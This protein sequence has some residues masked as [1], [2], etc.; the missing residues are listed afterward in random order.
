[1]SRQ[2]GAH[3][4]GALVGP[5]D[6]SPR[7]APGLAP[8]VLALHGFGGTP[9][10]VEIAV[11]AARAVGRR[12][13]APLLPGHGTHATELAR[14][15]WADW[16]SAA[17][18]ALDE[19]APERERAVVVGLS[20]GALLAI[21][22]AAS[23]PDRVAGVALLAAATRLAA[24]FPSLALAAVDRLRLPDFAVPK[25]GADLGDP[26]AR[27]THTTY[28]TQPVHAAISVRAAGPRARSRLPGIRAPLLV[29]HGARDRV[30][31]VANAAE[32]ARL[33]GSP[34]VRVRI[35]PRSRH[36]L[37]RD[38]E[39]AAVAEELREFVERCDA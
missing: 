27:R 13:F 20:M 21:H 17:E 10:E 3:P 19:V 12:A 28:E 1:M 2:S 25:A 34:D 26:E 35:F 9:L 30:C 31:P 6:P 16:A 38:V 18:L 37:T 39:R 14:T 32:I 8:G 36:I 15:R 33:A 11:S 4:R 7:R 24:P 29:L 23:R 5:G 22:L